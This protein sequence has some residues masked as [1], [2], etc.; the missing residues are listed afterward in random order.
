MSF[1]KKLFNKDSPT[2]EVDT[3]ISNST[4]QISNDVTDSKLSTTSTPRNDSSAPL[5]NPASGPAPPAKLA[6][7][8]G[9]GG[10]G[11][12]MATSMVGAGSMGGNMVG[13]QIIG[14]LVGQRI[15]QAKSHA[16]WKERQGQYLEG[17]ETALV[18]PGVQMTEREA[19]RAERR[20]K[21]WDSR[22]GKK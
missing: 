13:G 2:T 9:T 3:T 17:D 22:A 6:N 8:L 4:P 15:D 21:R 16:Y 19:K 11:A 1:F 10:M 20:K 7:A 18:T 12:G 14:N 5:L